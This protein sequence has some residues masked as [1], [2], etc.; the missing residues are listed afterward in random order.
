VDAL[1]GSK[2]LLQAMEEKAKREILEERVKLAPKRA[3][4]NPN[5]GGIG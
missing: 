2:Y 4:R 1:I 5:L 3:L